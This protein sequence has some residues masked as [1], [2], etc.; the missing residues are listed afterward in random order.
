MDQEKGRITMD[1]KVMNDKGNQYSAAHIECVEDEDD[2]LKDGDYF[3]QSGDEENY[4]IIDGE[5]ENITRP[6]EQIHE[7]GGLYIAKMWYYRC[8]LTSVDELERGLIP[9]NP[10]E[11]AAEKLRQ[12]YG[13]A[14]L[15]GPYTDVEWGMILGKVSA[16]RWV[17]GE[18]WDF[19]D[20]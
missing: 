20:T 2:G 7:A 16:L 1:D 10:G 13:K 11:A 8:Y 18:E 17:S 14:E 6:D 19:L 12:R 4:R 15:E 9:S 3:A 5:W